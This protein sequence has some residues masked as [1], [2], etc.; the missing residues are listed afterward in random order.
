MS[1]LYDSGNIVSFFLSF[2]SGDKLCLFIEC[3]TNGHT[4]FEIFRYDSTFL[5]IKVVRWQSIINLEFFFSRISRYI[6]FDKLNN[7]HQYMNHPSNFAYNKKN[8]WYLKNN[9][10][11]FSSF[12][13]KN[14]FRFHHSR[15]WTGTCIGEFQSL[16]RINMIKKNSLADIFKK[17]KIY[18]FKLIKQFASQKGS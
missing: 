3:K 13:S 17:K 12:N 5:E 10:R 18:L 11:H 14:L 4:F 16:N 6:V 1:C 7:M 9:I 8:L 15:L 2:D